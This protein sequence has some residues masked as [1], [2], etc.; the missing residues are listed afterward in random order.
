[1]LGSEMVVEICLMCQLS[2]PIGNVL[3]TETGFRTEGI[4]TFRIDPP[5]S[6]YPGLEDTSRFYQQLVEFP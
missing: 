4:Q 1:M 3:R 2:Q 5:D 6:R